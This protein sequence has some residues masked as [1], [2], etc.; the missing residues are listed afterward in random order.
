MIINTVDLI[1]AIYA[2]YE[3]QLEENDN[4]A[5]YEMRMRNN[6]SV[7]KFVKDLAH[8]YL[9]RGDEEL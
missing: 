1:E 3:V 5:F 9:N 2:E 4:I 6:V 7:I 8:I